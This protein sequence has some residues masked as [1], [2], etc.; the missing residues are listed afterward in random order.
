M[1]SFLPP[2][3]PFFTAKL[4]FDFASMQQLENQ[5]FFESQ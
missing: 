3:I 2:V 1:Y 5:K 4:T